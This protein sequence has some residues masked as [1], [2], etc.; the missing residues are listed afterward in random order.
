MLNKLSSVLA[1][2]LVVMFC[3]KIA[4]QDVKVNNY[5][6]LKFFNYLIEK[7]LFSDAIQ[8]TKLFDYSDLTAN[9]KDSIFFFKGFSFYNLQLT[10]SSFYCFQNLSDSSNFYSQS[11]LLSCKSFM[12][13]NRF[14]DAKNVLISFTPSKSDFLEIKKLNLAGIA[15]IE[16][17]Y[18]EYEKQI[19]SLEILTTT[20]EN[21][22]QNLDEKYKQLLEKK[23]KSPFVAG[24]LSGIVPGLGKVYSGK[25]KQGLTSF[26]A[27]TTF[28]VQAFEFYK[29]EGLKSPGFYVFGTLFTV[30]YVGNI[31]GSAI[32][33]KVVQDEYDY[34]INNKILLDI[35]IPIESIIK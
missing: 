6:E 25:P 32:S 2:V 29:K 24:A 35:R 9:Q 18:L 4:A 20:T 12:S 33:V 11:K 10:D 23:K 3:G 28:G 21:K 13:E 17:D 1:F 22:V 16:R 8:Q 30:F 34:E 7:K 14:V 5:K 26:L 31:W 19:K 15:L 27:V